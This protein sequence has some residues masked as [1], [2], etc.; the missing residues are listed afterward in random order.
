MAFHT[1]KACTKSLVAAMKREKV[2]SIEKHES[3]VKAACA[4]HA[5]NVKLIN[6]TKLQ[7][8]LE[9]MEQ[10]NNVHR[11]ELLMGRPHTG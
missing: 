2:F 3:D 9:G 10:K 8:V 11:R 7:E 1:S 4:K 5:E 6:Q